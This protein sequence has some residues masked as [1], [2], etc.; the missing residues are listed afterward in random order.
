ML[1]YARK[2]DKLHE[3]MLAQLTK[4]INSPETYDDVA[5]VGDG[6]R[7]WISEFA[8]EPDMIETVKTV[9]S[10]P[11]RCLLHLSRGCSSC[12]RLAFGL[13]HRNGNPTDV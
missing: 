1:V 10:H 2:R 3:E 7:K 12:S 4:R 5:D 8:R 11:V 9:R 6:C 13:T